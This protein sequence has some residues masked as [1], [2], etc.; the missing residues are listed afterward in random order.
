VLSWAQLFHRVFH[1]DVLDCPCGGR[2]A[3]VALVT[4]PEVIERILRHLD[5]RST[6]VEPAPA[7][8]PPADLAF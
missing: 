4:A 1:K 7:R 6:P 2:R 8:A 3:L 5:I